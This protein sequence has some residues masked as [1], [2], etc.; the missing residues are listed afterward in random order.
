MWNHNRS[1]NQFFQEIKA[2]V[3]L[4]DSS[5]DLMELVEN[6]KHQ[7]RSLRFNSLDYLLYC[8]GNI[9]LL[10][11]SSYLFWKTDEMF[12]LFLMIISLFFF[13]NLFIRFKKRQKQLTDLSRQIYQRKFLLDNALKTISSHPKFTLRALKSR[14]SEFSLGNHATEIKTLI[15]GHY[16]NTS[17]PFIFHYY[18]FFYATEKFSNSK[19]YKHAPDMAGKPIYQQHHRYGIIIPFEAPATLTITELKLPLELRQWQYKDPSLPSKFRKRFSLHSSSPKFAK[20]FLNPLTIDLIES[21]ANTFKTINIEIRGG[22]ELLF[23][24]DNADLL[25]GDPRQSLQNIDAFLSELR[26]ISKAD[27]LELLL[28]TLHRLTK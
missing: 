9:I 15:E 1:L 6:I 16:Q 14:F 26:S 22:K 18:H 2:Q 5:S 12:L 25:V 10:C 8:I 23:S 28:S 24:C 3:D 13:L 7:N 19:N 27:N 4:I 17:A 11:I 21:L 20:Q